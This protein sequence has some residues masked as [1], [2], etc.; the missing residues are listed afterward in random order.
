M[1]RITLLIVGLQLAFTA[2]ATDTDGG[3]KPKAPLKVAGSATVTVTAEAHSVEA[4]KTPNPVV[5]LDAEKLSESGAANLPGLMDV[6]LPGRAVGYGALGGATSLFINGSRS[7]DVVIL[8]DGIRVSDISLGVDLS[9]FALTGIDRVEVLSGASSTLYGADA[10]GGVVSLFSG[11]P[12][13]ESLSGHVLGQ[14]DTLGRL[15]TGALASYRWGSGWLTGAGDVEQS[16]QVTKTDNPYRQASGYVGLG[17]QFAGNWLLTLNHRAN[18]KGIPLPFN[19]GYDPM[20]WDPSREYAQG[21][22][23]ALWQS[24]TTASIKGGLTADLYGELNLGSVSQ[25]NYF[26]DT[27]YSANL[28]RQQ[29]NTLLAWKRERF[30]VSALADFSSGKFWNDDVTQAS[31]A[32]NSAVALEATYEALPELRLVA[33]ARQQW[34]RLEQYEQPKTSLD[35]LTWKIGANLLMPSGFRAYLNTGTAFNAP[36]LY[37]M[38]WN[39]SLG[40]EAP[41]NER[42]RSILGGVG[43]ERPTWWIRADAS[44]IEY[45]DLVDWVGGYTDGHYVNRSNIRVQGLELAAGLRQE[46][47]STEIFARTQEGRDKS[48]ES[49]R[50]LEVFLNRPFFSAGLRAECSYKRARF[51]AGASYIGHRYVYDSDLGG[52]KAEKTHFIDANLSARVQLT[53]AL[54]LTLRAERLLQDGITKDDW[55]AGKDMGKNNTALLPGYPGPARALSLEVRYSF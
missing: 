14:A 37:A 23:G 34:D 5:V 1:G 36:S 11:A 15:H 31:K 22:E 21:R 6:A 48:L 52:T 29:A 10:H 46:K 40:L 41:G 27:K 30:G 4:T 19:W 25:E 8:L 2:G 7:Q 35:Q 24:V 20:T 54:A 9:Q 44:R 53:Q 33:S 49:G 39:A 45:S 50:Q 18:Y 26:T 42:S 38:G 3:E 13:A 43:F 28:R 51:G 55:E 47:W 12:D 16:P 17:Q 32:Q